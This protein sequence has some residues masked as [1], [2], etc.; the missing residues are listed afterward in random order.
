[1]RL[2]RRYER[3]FE[4]FKGEEQLFSGNTNC[5][6]CVYTSTPPVVPQSIVGSAVGA[7]VS[8]TDLLNLHKIQIK[9]F[10]AQ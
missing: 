9:L 7:R 10:I 2:Y 6:H 8:E 3:R 1:M 4:T 5:V